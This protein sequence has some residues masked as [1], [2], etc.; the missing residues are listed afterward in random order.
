MMHFYCVLL[1]TQSASQSRGLKHILGHFASQVNA[2]WFKKTFFAVQSFA[3]QS[4]FKS[5]R[6]KCFASDWRRGKSCSQLCRHRWSVISASGTDL[7]G[8][9]AVK[10]RDV[11]DPVPR[12]S[13]FS[14]SSTYSAPVLFSCRCEVITGKCT[15]PS[16]L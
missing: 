3:V 2:S 11:F 12:L 15:S 14:L 16:M 5:N 1:C 13:S 8:G 10:I 4:F 9:P 6:G 7:H